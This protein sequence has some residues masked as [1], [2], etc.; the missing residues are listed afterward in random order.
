MDHH[1]DSDRGDLRGPKSQT[2]EVGATWQQLRGTH[3]GGR[4]EGGTQRESVG[5]SGVPGV[6]GFG[7]WKRSPRGAGEGWILEKNRGILDDFGIKK[8]ETH[9]KPWILMQNLTMQ[10]MGWSH[11]QMGI[12][13]EIQAETWQNYAGLLLNGIMLE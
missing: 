4:P 6:P 13:P 8:H 1:E 10:N 3:R 5:A 12:S 9:A 7:D 11:E 2:G